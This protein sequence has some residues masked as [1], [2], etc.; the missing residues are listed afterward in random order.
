[1]SYITRCP[2]NMFLVQSHLLTPIEPVILP[3]PIPSTVPTRRMTK[4]AQASSTKSST[5]HNQGQKRKSDSCVDDPAKIPC[6]NSQKCPPAKRGRPSTKP[7]DEPSTPCPPA[8]QGMTSTQGVKPKA[9]PL[10]CT[11][12]FSDTQSACMVFDEIYPETLIEIRGSD[13]EV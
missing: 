10:R 7:R 12:V 1:M 9:R 5:H 11:G 6:N 4:V 3:D 8:K 13:I 2:D